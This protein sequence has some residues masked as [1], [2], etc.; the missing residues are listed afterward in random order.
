M[1]TYVDTQAKARP[2]ARILVS[3]VAA[4]TARHFGLAPSELRMHTRRLPIV[5]A[6]MI[7][8]HLACKH[9]KASTPQIGWL[10]GDFDHSTV[11]YARDRIV[12]RADLAADVAAVEARLLAVQV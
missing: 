6:R 8:M 11:L 1:Q 12:E 3:D 2:A 10:L 7:A 9:T 5:T 4:A